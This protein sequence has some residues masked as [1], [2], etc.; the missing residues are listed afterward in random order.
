MHWGQLAWAS[1]P[2]ELQLQYRD[3]VAVHSARRAY[4][5]D[6]FYGEND[7]DRSMVIRPSV[8]AEA[9]HR[10]PLVH[11]HPETG[12]LGFFGCDGYIVD[13]EGDD[14][15]ADTAL[16]DLLRW[17]TQDH[18]VYRHRWEQGMLIIWDNR[19][20]LHQATGGYDGHHRLLHR[21]TIGARCGPFVTCSALATAT[22]RL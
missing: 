12:I 7:R 8:A 5:P 2:T 17:Q 21:T 13:L 1:M 20:V 10:H 4:A 14:T 11:A 3:I 9:V 18:F 19:S 6:G 15:L 16:H 22:K